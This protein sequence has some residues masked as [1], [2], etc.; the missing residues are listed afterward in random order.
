MVEVVLHVTVLARGSKNVIRG[1]TERMKSERRLGIWI[2]D[3]TYLVG[4]PRK[5][6]EETSLGRSH[7]GRPY[8]SFRSTDRVF[9]S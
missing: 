2:T 4:S 7:K 1:L 5:L 9:R 8:L 3:E 6:L